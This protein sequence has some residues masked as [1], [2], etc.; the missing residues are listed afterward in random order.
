[1][2]ISDTYPL[3]MIPYTNMAPY[4]ALGAPAGCR[5][6]DLSPRESLA[7][8]KEKRVWAA[9]APVGGLDE[10]A[11][12]VEFA[13]AYGI[14]ARGEVKSVLFFSDRP[15]AE[16][17]RRTRILITDQTASSL[18]LLYLLLG[19]QQGFDH[20]PVIAQ[21]RETADGEL[22]IGDKA[23]HQA[24]VVAAAATDSIHGQVTDLSRKWFALK[25]LPFVFARWVVRRDAPPAVRAAL[26]AWLEEFAARQDELV[27]AAVAAGV[28]YL[29][30]PAGEVRAYLQGIRYVLTD[31]DLRGQDLFLAEI[32][33]HGRTPLFA[34]PL[35]VGAGDK[36]L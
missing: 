7:A 14:A 19:Y 28:K 2:N 15:F 36:V 31:E 29:D 10:L 12:T 22:L 4:R 33:R 3:A 5:F 13:G 35:E 16:M 34:R 23:I 21:A 18:Q 6:V 9:A 26:L 32:R 30:L 24:R 8:L 27:R 25:G 11:D 1:M 17:D 20:L